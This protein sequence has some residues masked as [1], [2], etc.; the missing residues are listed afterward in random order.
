MYSGL[1]LYLL[2]FRLIALITKVCLRF[3]ADYFKVNNVLLP[4]KIVLIVKV[5]VPGNVIFCL[6]H[7]V[8]NQIKTKLYKTKAYIDTR[9]AAYFIF[10]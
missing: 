2:Y 4:V 1:L 8:I 5:A 3:S 6:K 7:F 10:F 9:Q